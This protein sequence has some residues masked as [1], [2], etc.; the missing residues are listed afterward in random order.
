[1]IFLHWWPWFVRENC[2]FNSTLC[3]QPCQSLS[4]GE[5]PVGH[6]AIYC[7]IFWKMNLHLRWQTIE[8]FFLFEKEV[9]LWDKT[10]K[11]NLFCLFGNTN[12]SVVNQRRWIESKD[13]S[14]ILSFSTIKL[15]I[16]HFH[17][18]WSI[19]KRYHYYQGHGL[20]FHDQ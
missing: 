20:S 8:T 12:S 13:V 10:C 16:K 4:Q 15:S 2:F 3:K 11:R 19:F 9:L 17:E 7:F 5:K 6:N 18:S 1:M 14:K